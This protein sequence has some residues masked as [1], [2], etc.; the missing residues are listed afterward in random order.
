[1]VKCRRSK[2]RLT[3]KELQEDS[4]RRQ[5]HCERCGCRFEAN[6][7]EVTVCSKCITWSDI[8]PEGWLW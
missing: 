1:M 5:V 8:E 7:T 3:A 6:S 4:Y 2:G